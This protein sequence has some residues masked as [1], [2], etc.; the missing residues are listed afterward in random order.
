MQKL[1]MK[2]PDLTKQ[3]ISKIAE[4]FPNCITE[5]HNEEGNLTR[6]IDFDLL[7]QELSNSIV[8]G[9]KERYQI[10]WPGKKEALVAANTP[11]AKTLRPCRKES[12]D[13]DTTQNL[14]IEGDNL[15]ALKLLQEAYLNKIK[16]IY[17]D[18]PYNTGND[19]VYNDRFVADKDVYDE[20]CGARD[21]EGNRLI[22]EEQYRQNLISNGRF[23]S[24]WLSMMYP[25]LKIARNLLKDDGV[26]FISIDDSEIDN[27]KKICDEVFGQNNFLGQI[28]VL[29]NPKG[30]SQ[31][32]YLATCHEYLIVYS[33]TKLEAGGINVQKTDEEVAEDYPLSDQNGQ[34]RSLELRNTHREF[35][36]HNR[37]NLYYPFFVD[38]KGNVSLEKKNGYEMILPI[39]DDGFEGCWTWGKEKTINE[40]HL[41]TARKVNEQWKIYRKSYAMDGNEVVTKSLKT[42]WSDRIFHTEKGQGAFND[43]F[44]SRHKIFQSP[45][46]VELIKTTLRMAG[47]QDSLIL[48]F[49]SGSATTAH[50]V[51]HLNAEDG[52][53]RKF[54]MVQLPE[55]TSEESE[56]YKAGYKTIAEIGKERIRRA[57]KKIKE[58]NSTKEGIEKLDIGFRVLKIDSSNMKDVYYSPDSITQETL[59]GTVDNI[60]EDRTP[61]D[62]LFQVLL[63]WGVDLTLPI[64][65]EEVLGKSVYFVD[66]DALAACF[67]DG[68]DDA[69]ARELAKRGAMRVVFKD[70]GFVDDES[71][72]NVEQI[73]K[74]LSPDT[75]VRSI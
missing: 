36:K 73:F 61:E 39:W 4:L 66:E 32:K 53:N 12:V 31:D 65:K 41:I 68:V 43:L 23:H 25:R 49:F 15:E 35:G 16:M 72:T 54:I 44:N 14:Y 6:S 17:I 40:S 74:Q 19:F 28:T 29:C 55:E 46:S 18:P 38:S 42:I 2:S 7:R 33:K 1:D 51:M 10:N 30:R 27:I 58:E 24:D 9:S 75:E 56:A 37:P 60:K 8:E 13:F 47:L 3:N 59:F 64:T 62:L 69:F 26:I 67:D 70:A 5:A 48:D 11:I 52:G 71:K 34:Y 50:A 22:S 21:E 20:E 45:K 57:G 63:D